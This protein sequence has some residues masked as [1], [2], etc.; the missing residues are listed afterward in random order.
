MTGLERQQHVS[1]SGW[2]VPTLTPALA[3]GKRQRSG[4]GAACA[5]NF[6]P[7]PRA[8]SCT[9][10][11]VP[12]TRSAPGP[13][14]APCGLGASG[15]LICVPLQHR[16]RAARGPSAQAGRSRSRAQ[17]ME[18][19]VAGTP[20]ARC[21]F[22]S[23]Q[24]CLCIYIHKL[25]VVPNCNRTAETFADAATQH[26]GIAHSVEGVGSSQGVNLAA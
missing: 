11:T 25:Y 8:G 10:T 5:G 16:L 22:H 14:G 3:A 20:A 2:A 24:T 19:A 7:F 18:M 13:A 4:P 9:L 12:S 17:W 1:S 23:C 6:Q 15:V 26:C 21:A